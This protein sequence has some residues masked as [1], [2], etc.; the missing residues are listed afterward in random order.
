[1]IPRPTLARLDSKRNW[2][3]SSPFTPTEYFNTLPDEDKKRI[4]S[5]GRGSSINHSGLEFAVPLWWVFKDHKNNWG[6]RNGYAFLVDYGQGPFAVTAAHVFKEYCETKKMMPTILCQLGCV[7]FDPEAQLI[8]H[9]EDLDIATF[10][11]NATEAKK[12]AR[13]S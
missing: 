10:R 5:S 4:L 3:L 1:V 6:L 2:L 13:L 9:R 12:S 8:S 11:I 7:V